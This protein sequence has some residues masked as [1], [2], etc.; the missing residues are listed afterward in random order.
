MSDEIE[1]NLHTGGLGAVEI[2]LDPGEAVVAEPGAMV[3]SDAGVEM[4]TSMDGGLFGAAKRMFGG[5][6][7]FV[8]RFENVSDAPCSAT[9]AAPYPGEIVP[10]DLREVGGEMRCQRDS[11]LCGADGIVTEV[12]FNKR[13]GSGLFGGEGFVMQRVAGD[14]L[15]FLHAGGA[16]VQRQ[17]AAGQQLK[18]DAG[19]LV[20]MSGEVDY[21]IGFVG[22]I[23]NALFGGE[24]L[25]Q[26]RLS[27]PGVV[28]LQTMPFQRLVDRMS[29]A[30]PVRREG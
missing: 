11:F 26:A 9:F 21:D 10:V 22:G 16:I 24:G 23:K 14:G 3:F 7:A 30:M 2:H 18:V 25:I 5:E 28:M 20:G 27:G 17:L 15:V 29:V 4:E 1:Y 19:C 8:T 12:T 6:Q 13:I